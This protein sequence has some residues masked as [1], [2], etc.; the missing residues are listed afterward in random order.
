M[1]IISL[2]KILTSKFSLII[3]VGVFALIAMGTTSKMFEAINDKERISLN[4]DIL[5]NKHISL[6]DRNGRMITRTGKV[7][8]TKNEL[9][10]SKDSIISKMLIELEASDIKL[11]KTEHML[12]ERDQMV[13]E[14]TSDI[15]NK[16]EM[17]SIL[18]LSLAKP[19]DSV[20]E[21]DINIDKVKV[22]EYKDS[23]IDE[24]LYLN[25]DKTWFRSLKVYNESFITIHWSRPGKNFFSRTWSWVRGKKNYHLDSKNTN[26]YLISKSTYVGI[27]KK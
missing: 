2:Y 24:S 4:Y 19:K 5:S 15:L 12:Y 20:V 18:N 8:L 6:Q 16:E 17:I 3:M 13:H 11:R 21:L 22:F 14:I 27:K 9:I 7:V 23:F 25:Y 10:K 1:S 26:P